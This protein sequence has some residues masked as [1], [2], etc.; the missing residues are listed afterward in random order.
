MQRLTLVII[1]LVVI[2]AILLGLYFL[3][4]NKK[5]PMPNGQEN[6]AST[7]FEVQ[8][9]K[10]EILTEGS[11]DIAKNGD[12]VTVNYTGTLA[13]GTKFDS[14]IDRKAPFTFVLGKNKVIK[15]WDLGVLGMK[16]GDK[17]KLTIPRTDAAH[18]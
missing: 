8:G 7:S 4:M 1:I 17:R 10:V 12:S 9:M 15:G 13:D 14:S 6:T 11:G 5:S 18:Q 3:F 2:V 16:I